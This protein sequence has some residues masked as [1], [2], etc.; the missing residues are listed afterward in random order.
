MPIK[1]FFCYSRRDEALLD[2]LKAHLRPLQRQGL[3]DLWHDR[4]ISAGDDW[5]QAITQQLNEA[6]IIL[7]LVSPD[8]M[9]SDYCYGKEMQRALERHTNKE[10]VVI[11][12]ILRPVYW[13]GEPLG[14]LQ[15]LPTDGKPITGTGWHDQDSAF[16]DVVMGMNKVIQ[17]IT[18]LVNAMKFVLFKT[19][20]GHQR[21]VNSVAISRDGNLLVSGSLDGKIKIW[22]LLTG[23]EQRTLAGYQGTVYCVAISEDGKTLVTGSDDGTINVWK[24]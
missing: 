11:P 23:K 6:D 16:Y 3:I 20:G 21:E 18:P 8:F 9:E 5:E 10:C 13:H 7:L 14:K 15:A 17:E 22:N 19:L 24:A 12:I 1:I 2:K 4:D